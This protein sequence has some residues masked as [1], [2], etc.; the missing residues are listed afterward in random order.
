M[1]EA[2]AE[3]TPRASWRQLAATEDGKAVWLGLAILI[4]TWTVTAATFPRDFAEGDKFT[5]PL[6]PYS[7]KLSGW[8]SNPVDAVYVAPSKD[9]SESDAAKP[10]N[11]LLGL[12]AVALL[13]FFVFGVG[14]SSN[15]FA[16]GYFMLFV[17][18]AAAML[19]A[20]QTTA[21]AYNLEYALW[22]LGI[23]VAI[24]LTIGTPKFMRPALSTEFYIKTGL[25]LLGSELLLPQLMI[26][27][28]PG[29]CVAWICTPITFIT[30][31]IF[32]QK[33][34]KMESRSL[35]MVISADM[36]V[37]GVSAAIAT[38]AA[39]KA[40]K[41]ELTLAIGISLTF[42]VLMMVVMPAIIDAAGM[43]Q[44]LGGA[45]IGGTID[46]T[47]AVA[48]AGELVGGQAQ[49]VATTVK[50]LQNILIG[51][52]AFG[53]A[54]YWVRV[55]ERL[56]DANRS[57]DDPAAPPSPQPSLWMIWERFPKFILGFFAASALATLVAVTLPHGGDQMKSSI[58]VTKSLMTWFFAL[59]FVSIGL[60]IDFAQVRDSLK[61]G[62]PLVL[63][64]CGQTLNLLLTFS[65]AWV[66]FENVFK[67][68]IEAEFEVKPPEVVQPVDG[69][70]DD[71]AIETPGE[72]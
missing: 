39:C 24:N 8:E 12:M 60:E 6:V 41:E 7:G 20:N 38:A 49:K 29:F 25:V 70:G 15:E 44:I 10:V 11:H 31:Y 64:I 65:M 71:A 28:I 19:L 56:P 18:A 34:L 66:M 2:P 14:K 67:K 43:S 68:Q 16:S 36:A 3:T 57:P 5:S 40:K 69:D 1:S 61:G 37:C 51:V 42:T 32:G 72:S 9:S 27:G 53:V 54:T 22:A 33:V 26:L 47:G 55:V 50:L 21:K 62:K 52:L 59:A 45:W 46:S 4:V 17:L 63:Y 35:N 48:A 58:E 30:T 13:G 23:G